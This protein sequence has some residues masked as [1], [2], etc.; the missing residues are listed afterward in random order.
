ME[1]NPPEL[2]ATMRCGFI[3]ADRLSLGAP[4]TPEPYEDLSVCAGYSTTLPEVVDIAS[5]F[6][7]WE[8]GQLAMACDGEQPCRALFTGIA[9]L[10][11]AVGEFESHA[12]RKQSEKGHG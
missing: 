10:K 7:H 6:H 12:M 11:G 3:P 5:N 2:R 9:V 8:T 4:W 1:F